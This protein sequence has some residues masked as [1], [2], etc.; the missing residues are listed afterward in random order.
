M[1]E[2]LIFNDEKEKGRPETLGR[3]SDFFHTY[4]LRSAMGVPSSLSL[5]IPRFFI[6]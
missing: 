5:M 3:P 4:F 6:K 2:R 1:R